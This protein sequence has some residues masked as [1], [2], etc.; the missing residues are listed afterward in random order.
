MTTLPQ[1][2]GLGEL[3][4]R[5]ES[6]HSR[7]RRVRLAGGVLAVVAVAM[8]ALLLSVAATGYWPDQ[9]PVALRWAVIVL[10]GSAVLAA[11]ALGVLRVL[12]WRQNAAMTAR[13]IEQS[14]PETRNDLINSVLLAGDRDQASP[15]LVQLAIGQA[16]HRLRT[17]DLHKS[18]STRPLK[19]W[20]SAAGAST[21][22]V[23][24]FAFTQP[25]PFQRGLMGMIPA[26]Y[27]PSHNTLALLSLSPGDTQVFAGESVTVTVRIDNPSAEVLRGEL[28]VEGR[29][30]PL[31]LVPRQGYSVFT[32][33]LD[34]VQQDTRYSVRIGGSRWPQDKP[35]YT[36]RVLQRI[37]VEGLDLR[38]DYPP[39]IPKDDQTVRNADGTIDAPVGTRVTVR[40]RLADPVPAAAIELP[41]QGQTPMLPAPGN[42][43]F[44]AVLPVLQDG[45]Y[46]IILRDAQGRPFQQLPDVGADI[47]AAS[48]ADI[49]R[50]PSMAGYYRIHARPDHRPKI[51]FL[52]P[53][54]DVSVPP[55]GT[56]ETV[57]KVSDDHGLTEAVLLAG[58]EGAPL[59]PVH[60]YEVSGKTEADL[61]YAFR[62]PDTYVEGDVVVYQATAKDNRMLDGIGGPQSNA[63]ATYKI[64]IQDPAKVAEEKA[65]RFEQLRQR[66]LALLKIQEAQRVNALIARQRH[67]ELIDHRNG[68][69]DVT[70]RATELLATGGEIVTGQQ[71]IKSGLLDLTQNF[72][73]DPEMVAVQ[74][75]VA[76]LATNEAATA[77]EQAQVLK[78]VVGGWD[79]V[80]RPFELLLST[81]DSILDTLKTLLAILPSLQGKAEKD[82]ARRAGED[83]PPD[84]REKL[85]QLKTDLEDFIEGEKR[86][87]Q[88]TQQLAKKPVDD[89]TDEDEAALKDLI[90]AQDKWE[91]FLGEAFT[92]FSK[93]MQQDFSNPS[94]LKELLSI[95][96]DVTMAKDALKKKA[97]EIATAIED[98][99][100]ENAE[101]LTANIEKWLPDEPDRTKWAMED[102]TDDMNDSTEAPELPTELEDLMGK[103]LEE[104]EDLFEEMEDLS[105]KYS[106]SG[107][108]GIGWDAMDGPISNMNAQGVTGNQLPNPSEIQGR[109]GEGRQGKSA[110]EFVEDKAVGKGGRRTP[111]RLSPEP[112]QKGEVNDQSSEPAGGAT[113]GGKLSGAAEEGLEGPV[114]PPLAREMPRLAGK[115]AQLLN[116]AE[117]IQEQFRQES[118]GNFK[119]L[120]AI[121]LM[122][123][124]QSDL[125]NYRYQNVLRV[126]D[127]VLD[128]L[129][130][131]KLHIG[132]SIDVVTDTASAMPKYIRDDIA[133]AQNKAL[134]PEYREVLEQYYR[135]LSEQAGE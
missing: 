87:V 117:R 8:T 20:A 66:L 82:V 11:L 103:L 118:Y 46:R 26:R 130:E 4:E 97:E 17:A 98:N 49:L 100:I 60:R 119:L 91:K 31:A 105:S 95:K 132:R 64:L 40:V 67:P 57:L 2:Q 12:V 133:D 18:I 42:Q 39:Y 51:A 77:V 56:L 38:Y 71:Q 29:D 114:P 54:K 124:V 7:R 32:A 99:G 75:A 68:G 10:S 74:Q 88:A 35:H 112:F 48:A 19:R 102:P 78:Q 6:V 125:E 101:S 128:S 58:K 43:H 45:A 109:S 1:Y 129:G 108:K 55:G 92:D 52:A 73:F 115:H 131:S 70:A 28:R 76:L 44:E 83:M 24:A 14:L 61:P 110:G 106:M 15:E 85:E 36:I 21:L 120:Q 126:R 23:L 90:A 53:R 80:D 79:K 63:S 116:R 135:R 84:V 25:G 122:T 30:A 121:T 107:D 13:F 127:T 37:E 93:L 62:L 69:Q 9:P 89:F 47:L 65:R 22:L 111:T 96:S 134:P 27:V 123:R 50:D 41:Q 113:G 86:V 81:Q 5:I 33:T 16:A 34:R 104:E 3:L 94:L 59:L 72:P